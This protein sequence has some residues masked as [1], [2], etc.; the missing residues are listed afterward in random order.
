MRRNNKKLSLIITIISYYSRKSTAVLITSAITVPLLSLVFCV[1]VSPLALFFIVFIA[2]LITHS[3]SRTPLYTIVNRCSQCN[4]IARDCT[5]LFTGAPTVHIVHHGAHCAHWVH[6]TLLFT[7]AHSAYNARSEYNCGQCAQ[8]VQWVQLLAMYTVVRRVGN[9][10]S[11]NSARMCTVRA[12]VNSEYSGNSVYRLPAVFTMRAM[13][14]VCTGER[15]SAHSGRSDAVLGGVQ[16]SA[17]SVNARVVLGVCR[18]CGRG[19][20]VVR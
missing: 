19:S 18:G 16:G 15:R 2:P 7:G 1:P 5:L 14:A 3:S 11:G 8:W 20:R 13:R 12:T 9:G 4:H 17:Y 6:C 10:R